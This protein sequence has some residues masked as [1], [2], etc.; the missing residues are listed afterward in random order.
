MARVKGRSGLCEGLRSM[1]RPFYC[2]K[3]GDSLS[4]AG[5][6]CGATMLVAT[7][8]SLRRSE[9]VF[10]S[11]WCGGESG[12]DMTLLLIVRFRQALRRR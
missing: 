4:E 1:T 7:R 11:S 12:E 5:R 10:D 3:V 2:R 6:M 9:A 8:R